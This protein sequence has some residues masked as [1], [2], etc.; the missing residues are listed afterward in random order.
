MLLWARTRP[1]QR[2]G[3]EL[4][5][6]RPPFLGDPFRAGSITAAEVLL[7]SI[8]E[9]DDRNPGQ[10]ARI[11]VRDECLLLCRR[12]HEAPSAQAGSAYDVPGVDR[13]AAADKTLQVVHRITDGLPHSV[14]GQL[15]GQ[16]R[17]D[18]AVGFH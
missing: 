17:L 3:A 14:C 8:G 9:I 4:A 5:L 16:E 2:Q 10:R 12:G 18:L 13:P 7:V 11:A 15:E 1:L 6:Q